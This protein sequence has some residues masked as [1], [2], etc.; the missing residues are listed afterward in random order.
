M[1]NLYG[2]LSVLNTKRSLCVAASMLAIS[3]AASGCGPMVDLTYAV[4]K[5]MPFYDENKDAERFAN[6]AIG[7]LADGDIGLA[8]GYANKALAFNPEHTKAVLVMAMIYENTNRNDMAEILYKQ[9]IAKAP[10]ERSTLYMM[11]GLRPKSVMEIAQEGV[12]RIHEPSPQELAQKEVPVYNLAQNVPSYSPVLSVY[13]D[14]GVRDAYAK[15][16][17]V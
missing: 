8:E 4:G 16:G 13:S 3:V 11:G 12:S 10:Y 5:T 1:C 14:N 7:A 15:E 9:I 17:G 2:V 6:K